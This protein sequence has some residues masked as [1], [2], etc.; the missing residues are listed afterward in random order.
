MILIIV[1]E[2]EE[3]TTANISF[4]AAWWYE[5]NLVNVTQDLQSCEEE[6]YFEIRLVF[7]YY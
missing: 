3:C 2:R 1:K 5:S 7:L 6:V 4:K